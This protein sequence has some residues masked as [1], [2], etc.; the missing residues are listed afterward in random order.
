MIR[1]PPRYTLPDTLFPY[2]TLFRSRIDLPA[3]EPRG[4]V[5]ADLR[6]RDATVRVIGMHLGLIG[7]WRRRQARAV[8]LTLEAL[9]EPRP[10]IMMGDLNEWTV[11]GGCLAMFARQHHVASPGPSFHSRRPVDAPDRILPR[12]DTRVERAGVPIYNKNRA[13]LSGG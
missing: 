12:S 10:T 4:A 1:G 8:L 11:D 13:T 6:V 7:F 3:F 9:E 5:L 2:P